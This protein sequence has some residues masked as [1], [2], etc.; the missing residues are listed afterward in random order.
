M[1][2]H[3]PALYQIKSVDYR[4]KKAWYCGRPCTTRERTVVRT[5]NPSELRQSTGHDI[6]ID[7][8]ITIWRSPAPN[9]RHWRITL[10]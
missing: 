3:S 10:L 8:N 7:R 5:A 6:I 9:K 1:R 2:G 4:H